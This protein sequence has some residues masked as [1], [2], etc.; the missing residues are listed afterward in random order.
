MKSKTKEK[1]AKYKIGDKVYWVE[2]IPLRL[3]HGTIYGVRNSFTCDTITIGGK[4][5]GENR[6]EEVLIKY[7][8]E[9]SAEEHYNRYK[10]IWVNTDSL[11][12]RKSAYIRQSGFIESRIKYLNEELSRVKLITQK[13]K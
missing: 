6:I 1:K 11:C 5:E 13:Q 4:Q 9:E 7:Y 12:D 2:F 8:D 10:R 3:Y